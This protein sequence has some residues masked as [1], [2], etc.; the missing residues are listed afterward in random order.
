[1]SVC[2]VRNTIPWWAFVDSVINIQVPEMAGSVLL[3]ARASVKCTVVRCKLL[4]QALFR[5]LY[6][7]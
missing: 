3:R 6:I 1:M 4:H 7:N 2:S 5:R